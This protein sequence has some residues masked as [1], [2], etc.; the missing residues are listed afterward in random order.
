MLELLRQYVSDYVTLT[1]EDFSI[2]ATKIMVRTFD[3]HVQLIQPGEVE[4][5]MNFV[6]KGLVR[7]YFYKGRTEV[8][9]VLARERELVSASASFLSGEPSNYFV[10]T[11]EPTTLLS[12]TREDLEDVYRQSPRVERVGRLMT[13]QFVLQK[14]EWEQ[15]YMRMDTRERFIRF[16]EKDPGL[17]QRVPQKYLASYLNMKPETFSRLKHLLKK[18]PVPGR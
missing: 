14:E 8:V 18:R 13:T 12:L 2:L 17:I 11:L 10:E 7:Q 3:K 5:H 6:V 1:D 9:T 15:G 4:R 16:V